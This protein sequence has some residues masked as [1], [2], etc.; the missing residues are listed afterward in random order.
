MFGGCP[1]W[2]MGKSCDALPKLAETT[3][4]DFGEQNTLC[5]D[6]VCTVTRYKR[7]CTDHQH[8]QQNRL[9]FTYTVLQGTLPLMSCEGIGG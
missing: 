4:L 5:V 1:K 8:N 7:L 6:T 2:E 3:V 9:Y